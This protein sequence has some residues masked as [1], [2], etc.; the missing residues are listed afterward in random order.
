[1]T[2]APIK[3]HPRCLGEHKT[4]LVKVKLDTRACMEI[5]NNFECYSRIQVM[6]DGVA[7]AFGKVTELVD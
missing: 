2:G 6:Q 4:A 1:M 5:A 7:V 3:K